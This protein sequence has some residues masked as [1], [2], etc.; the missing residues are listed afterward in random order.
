M[1]ILR[2]SDDDVD[3]DHFMIILSHERVRILNAAHK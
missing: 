3:D 2:D 1:S